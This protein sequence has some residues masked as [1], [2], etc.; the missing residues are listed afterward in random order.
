[1]PARH[2]ALLIASLT[3]IVVKTRAAAATKW[4][5]GEAFRR[6]IFERAI[7]RRAEMARRR[8]RG[9]DGAPARCR[10]TALAAIFGRR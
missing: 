8:R 1:M 9:R 2:G 3:A 7:A 5:H 6:S 10:G 4:Q